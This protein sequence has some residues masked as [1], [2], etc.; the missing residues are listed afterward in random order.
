MWSSNQAPYFSELPDAARATAPEVGRGIDAH[1]LQARALELLPLGELR[2][3]ELAFRGKVAH[4]L[5]RF[6]V[7]L[8]ADGRDHSLLADVFLVQEELGLTRHAQCR[9][10]HE[11]L[12]LDELA[13]EVTLAQG[14]LEGLGALHV[15]DGDPVQRIA[16]VVVEPPGHRTGHELGRELG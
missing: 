6:G 3:L 10:L 5:A 8:V 11:Y 15:G 7:E 16:E 12:E 9:L 13:L 14:L 1:P 4:P 2:V